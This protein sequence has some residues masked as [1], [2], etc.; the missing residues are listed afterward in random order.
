V[1]GRRK[2]LN[3]QNGLGVI[4]SGARRVTDTIVLA[5]AHA[6]A[7]EALREQASLLNLTHDTVF[8]RDMHDVITYWNRGA[9]DLYGWT[10]DEAVG[11]VT[12]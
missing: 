3:G 11:Q 2:T 8:V 12:H 1:S 5:A 6:L 9:E 10:R 4:A 7:E